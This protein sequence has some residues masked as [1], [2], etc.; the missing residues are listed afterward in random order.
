MGKILQLIDTALDNS[1]PPALIHGDLW[2]T[3]IIFTEKEIY[4][5]DSAVYYASREIEIAYLEFVGNFYPPLIEAYQANYPLS[6][7]Y[8]ERKNFYLLYPYLIHLHLF[9]EMYL[10]GLRQILQYYT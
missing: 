8:A 4:L 9:G 2:N 7:Q 3:N 6:K 5:I 10:P 1:E